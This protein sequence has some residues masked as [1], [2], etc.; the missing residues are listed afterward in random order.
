M[1]GGGRR[2][3]GGND[4]GEGGVGGEVICRTEMD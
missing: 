1:V 4:G 3:R 2:S